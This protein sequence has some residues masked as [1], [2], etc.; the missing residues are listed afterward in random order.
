M[1]VGSYL[2]V[3][4]FIMV[5]FCLEIS[6]LFFKRPPLRVIIRGYPLN[7]SPTSTL[8]FYQ[9]KV[10]NRVPPTKPNEV[11]RKDRKPKTSAKILLSRYNYGNNIISHLTL[12]YLTAL[13]MSASEKTPTPTQINA[14]TP[15]RRPDLPG[16]VRGSGR[17]HAGGRDLLS[18]PFPVQELL[19]D[20]PTPGGCSLRPACRPSP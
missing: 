20:L 3:C 16:L 6:L 7:Y 8:L 10:K 11:D 14:G 19:H 13:N 18:L 5:R 1:V 15:V 4:T 12:Q 9:L 2:Y 17:V